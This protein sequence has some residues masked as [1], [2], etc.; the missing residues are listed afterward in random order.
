MEMSDLGEQIAQMLP[1]EST[2]LREFFRR[3]FS[4]QHYRIARR[5]RICCD[6]R[7]LREWIAAVDLRD[8]RLCWYEEDRGADRL[9]W[10]KV[11]GPPP[12][13]AYRVAHI[14]HEATEALRRIVRRH[15]GGEARRY[16]WRYESARRRYARER[17]ELGEVFR[18]ALDD[19]WL[20]L[21]MD[22][23]FFVMETPAWRYGRLPSYEVGPQPDYALA[24]DL[25][26]PISPAAYKQ[27]DAW[28]ERVARALKETRPRILQVT[29]EDLRDYA[30]ATGAWSTV[31]SYGPQC[32]LYTAEWLRQG[33]PEGGPLLRD[34]VPGL[35]KAV[36]ND[37]EIRAHYASLYDSLMRYRIALDIIERQQRKMQQKMHRMQSA[38]EAIRQLLARGELLETD[39]VAPI[40]D[41]NGDCVGCS[42]LRLSENGNRNKLT[43]WLKKEG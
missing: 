11:D 43:V 38:K 4:E 29:A 1:Q 21:A 7:G 36:E 16:H 2:A 18:E 13:E 40:W 22:A 35:W 14:L 20:P 30:L 41:Q 12:D 9:V 37:P 17:E 39:L 34:V 23:V 5:R 27:V 24:A 8:P 33:R 15:W 25:L 6:A 19:V 31:L 10:V 28:Q 26:D 42:V 32:L 3:E